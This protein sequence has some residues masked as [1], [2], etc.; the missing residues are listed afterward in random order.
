LWQRNR[1]NFVKYVCVGGSTFLIDLGLLVVLHEVCHVPVVIA[2]TISYWTSIV[3]NFAMNRYWT[4]ETTRSL[5]HHAMAYGLLLL[6]N[7]IVTI[8]IIWALGLV[9]VTYTL[10]K[11]LAVGISMSWTYVVY[12]KV[13]FV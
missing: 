7:Y 3:Y 11:I 1:E 4:F 5:K 10:A 6:T 12:K 8:A 13:I 2:A 9:G